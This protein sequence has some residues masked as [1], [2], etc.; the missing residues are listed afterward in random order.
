MSSI[1]TISQPPSD[2][3][4]RLGEA[5]TPEMTFGPV[6][7]MDDEEGGFTYSRK[8]DTDMT[9]ATDVE[10]SPTGSG[11]IVDARLESL[12]KL[13][14]DPPP[15][16]DRSGKVPPAK[17]EKL[18]AKTSWTRAEIGIPEAVIVLKEERARSVICW[19]W[20]FGD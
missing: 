20:M 13:Q 9:T 11:E 10:S 14:G 16:L 5:S 7:I 18:K 1:I 17:P 19:Y 6:E 15:V 4:N 8:P 2:P 3:G 12:K